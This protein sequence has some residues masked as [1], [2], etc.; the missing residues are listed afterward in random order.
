MIIE[1]NIKA[2]TKLPPIRK[3]AKL[4]E[5][6]NTTIVKAYELL[7][8]EGYVY[9]TVGSGTFVS[10]KNRNTSKSKKYLWTE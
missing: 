5:V 10:D 1:D 7:E 2:S 4:L 8:K 3:I 6:N 9:K